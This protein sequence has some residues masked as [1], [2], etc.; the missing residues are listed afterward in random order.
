[1]IITGTTI[2]MIVAI[3][4]YAFLGPPYDSLALVFGVVAFVVDVISFIAEKFR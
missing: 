2:A 1:M 3:L 4:G